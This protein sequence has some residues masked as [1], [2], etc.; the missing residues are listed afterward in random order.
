MEKDEKL[1]KLQTHRTRTLGI[2][3]VAALLVLGIV[4]F[5]STNNNSPAFRAEF[6]SIGKQISDH[7]AY[8]FA[9]ETA[10]EISF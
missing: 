2:M 5:V 7:L 10:D 6:N 1:R 4:V 9:V 8:E 3:S